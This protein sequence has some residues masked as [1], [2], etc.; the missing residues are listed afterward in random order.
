MDLRE[1]ERNVKKIGWNMS[2]I[3]REMEKIISIYV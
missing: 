1:S 2:G 3:E